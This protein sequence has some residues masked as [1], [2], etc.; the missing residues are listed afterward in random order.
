MIARHTPTT[1]SGTAAPAIAFRQAGERVGAVKPRDGQM[2]PNRG[3]YA[4]FG[5]GNDFVP[6]PA[7]VVYFL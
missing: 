6:R 3:G 7:F 1:G 4:K 2:R 5:R